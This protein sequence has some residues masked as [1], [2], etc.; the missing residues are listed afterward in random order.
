MISNSFFPGIPNYGATILDHA[1]LRPSKVSV[2][3]WWL[4]PYVL[5]NCFTD[6]ARTI[7]VTADGNVLGGVTADA[8][9]PLNTGAAIWKNVGTGHPNGLG[10]IKF[11]GTDAMA[12]ALSA[13]LAGWTGPGN[14]YI[15]MRIDDITTAGTQT[16]FHCGAS[17]GGGAVR[18]V[19]TT[20]LMQHL[21]QGAGGTTYS[22]Q[23][24][25]RTNADWLI[26][27]FRYDGA[28][29]TTEI[30]GVNNGSKAVVQT[31]TPGQIFLGGRTLATEFARGY[32]AE[33]I[34]TVGNPTDAEHYG[35]IEYLRRVHGIE[36]HALHSK[37]GGS[38]SNNYGRSP[39][40]PV[41]SIQKAASLLGSTLDQDGRILCEGDFR[42]ECAITYD[43]NFEIFPRPGYTSDVYATR[44]FTGGWTLASG[45]T[46]YQDVG[47]N[48]PSA[49]VDP[50]F[51]TFPASGFVTTMAVGSDH[52]VL[53][54]GGAT[55]TPALMEIGY[56]P[57]SITSTGEGS[58]RLYINIG[59]DP[60]THTVEVTCRKSGIR[61]ESNDYVVKIR[62]MRFFGGYHGGVVAGGGVR[63]GRVDIRDSELCYAYT[64]GLTGR[65]YPSRIEGRRLRMWWNN[66]DGGGS[67]ST[68]IK[69][70]DTETA[71]MRL[72]DCDAQWNDGDGASNHGRGL[73]ETL[74][75]D[76]SNNGKSGVISI[77]DTV[78]YVNE[79]V[80]TAN[81][82]LVFG[83]T[84][85]NVSFADEPMTGYVKNS[86]V[87][88]PLNGAPNIYIAPGAVVVNQNNVLV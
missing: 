6:N 14:I 17:T 10:C 22:A 1:P 87:Y 55:T 2:V 8:G 23:L 58:Y 28:N 31:H 48:I 74:R 44:Q 85:G 70:G 37:E 39:S 38:S 62:N 56:D 30:G 72:I 24:E 84:T 51:E 7:P 47:Q 4:R 68:V 40:T 82:R 57:I 43:H 13:C 50:P 26:H 9:D 53:R 59:T 29:G 52:Q 86:R 75:G 41:A 63:K 36:V 83:S 88:A 73:I 3:E 20:A 49:L 21:K 27:S 32:V 18:F 78:Q 71:S 54:H 76:Y 25:P 45:T 19:Q 77:E 81:G 64:S 67:H 65:A 35:M 5:A 33:V 80:S 12:T 79:I 42:S 15:V 66:N 11:D 16:W 46:Y 34:V 61:S 60:N 69:F